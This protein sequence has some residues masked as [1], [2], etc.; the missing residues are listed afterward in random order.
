MEALIALGIIGFIWLAVK[1]GFSFSSFGGI[2]ISSSQEQVS[3]RGKIV[4][5]TYNKQVLYGDPSLPVSNSNSISQSQD[6]CQVSIDG[7]HVVI[8]GNLE[9]LKVNGKMV[10]KSP[11][12]LH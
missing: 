10:L 3:L 9:S 1:K 8:K 2:S 12:E 6:G 7:G 5:V 4:S 11:S